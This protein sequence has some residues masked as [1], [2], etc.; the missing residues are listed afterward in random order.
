MEDVPDGNGVRILSV[1]ANSP[2]DDSDLWINDVILKIDGTE[3]K[4][5]GSLR[6]SLQQYDIGDRIT[7]AVKRGDKD[8]KIRLTLAKRDEVSPENARSKQQNSMGSI[9][10]RRRKDFPDSFQHD[11]ML[12]SKTCGGPIV[13]LSGKVVGI[14]IARAGRVSSLALT[15]ATVQP[16]IAKLKTGEFA[17]ALVNKAKIEEIDAELKELD[18][19]LGKLPKSKSALEKKYSVEKA[20]MEELEKTMKALK[21]RLESIEN[22]ATEYKTDL[23]A[24]T[25]EL[26]TAEKTRQRL[27]ADRKQLA[28]GSR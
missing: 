1:V 26:R 9:L 13:D 27:E 8:K 23:D 20:R 19:K 12:N 18:V 22:K 10:S 3:I 21:E 16:V 14:N 17:P 2:A 11:S 15:V 7:L 6:G 24:I 4:D 25:K 28:T 5:I